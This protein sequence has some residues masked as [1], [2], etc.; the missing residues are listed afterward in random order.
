[1]NNNPENIKSKYLTESKCY[2]PIDQDNQF[3]F[4][5]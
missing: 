1:M 3:I 4:K 5:R 2:S